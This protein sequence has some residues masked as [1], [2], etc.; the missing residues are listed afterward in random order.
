MAKNGNGNKR[1]F[2]KPYKS[3]MFRDKDPVIDVLRTVK[4]DKK[5]KTTD[6]S[7]DSG[8]ST[9]TIHNWFRGK[10]RRPQFATVAAVARAMH[11]IEPVINLLRKGK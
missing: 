1:G 9:T 7:A 2:L 10:T 8:V 3:Y 4:E 6:I 11:G 5:V